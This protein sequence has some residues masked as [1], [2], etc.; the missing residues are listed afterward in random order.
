MGKKRSHSNVSERTVCLSNQS[1]KF[2]PDKNM[3]VL[4]RID[5]LG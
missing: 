1:K 4:A 5:L 2:D 3:F